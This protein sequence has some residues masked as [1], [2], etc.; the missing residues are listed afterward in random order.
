MSNRITASK[1]QNPAEIYN[2]KRRIVFST[3][4]KDPDL[5]RTYLEGYRGVLG[6]AG[7]AGLNAELTF[8]ERHRKDFGLVPALDAA[9][10]P[11]FA[12]VID[13]RMH[14]IDV[15]TNLNYKQLE[16]YEPLQVQ[17]D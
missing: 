16:S 2:Q 10:A 9:D 11:A 7:Y 6:A 15:T 13:G 4:N 8:Y 1:S 3:F 14:R 17:G 12:G 5:A